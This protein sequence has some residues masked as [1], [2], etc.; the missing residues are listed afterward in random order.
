MIQLGKDAQ[1]MG[2]GEVS[3][4][5]VLVH[6]ADELLDSHLGVSISN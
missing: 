4:L 5:I 1:G 6:I 3:F 2:V